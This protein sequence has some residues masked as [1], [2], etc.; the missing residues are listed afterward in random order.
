MQTQFIYITVSGFLVQK[1]E[2][3]EEELK[4]GSL[5]GEQACFN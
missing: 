3:I 4:Q 5:F 2:H 1:T